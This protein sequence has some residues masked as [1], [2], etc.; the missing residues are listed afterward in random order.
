MPKFSSKVGRHLWQPVESTKPNT[1]SI[2][3]KNFHEMRTFLFLCVCLCASRRLRNDSVE[4]GQCR[5]FHGITNVAMSV[6]A[7]RHGQQKTNKHQEVGI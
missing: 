6:L 4:I 7:S 1:G 2:E 3:A 5:F